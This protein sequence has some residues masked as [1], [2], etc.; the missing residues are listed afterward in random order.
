MMSDFDSLREQL[1]AVRQ[2][3]DSAQRETASAGEQLDRLKRDYAALSRVADPQNGA[4]QEQLKALGTRI[5]RA[6]QI[7][8]RRSPIRAR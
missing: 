1:S 8:Q 5:E 3:R 4:Q 2:Q 6:E 7:L